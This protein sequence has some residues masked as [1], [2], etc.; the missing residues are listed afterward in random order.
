[1]RWPRSSRSPDAAFDAAVASLTLCSIGDVERALSA[2]H[3]VVRP[4]GEL[5]FFEHVA[6]PLRAARALQ[7]AADA[8]VW[9][10]L[11]GGCHLA[12][13]T[14]LLE[15]AG[16]EIVRCERFAFR[17]PPLDPPKTHIIGLARRADGAPRVAQRA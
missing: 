17:I 15:A 5:R 11:S 7:R 1:M 12:R 16:F 13:H 10:R 2:L 14:G 6:S 3:R 9:P 8:T 4:D